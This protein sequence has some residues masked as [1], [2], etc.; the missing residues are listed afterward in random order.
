MKY[1]ISPTK[2]E[3]SPEQVL[4]DDEFVFLEMHPSEHVSQ[5][6]DRDKIN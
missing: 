2:F 5:R 4:L 3:K 1:N 6:P